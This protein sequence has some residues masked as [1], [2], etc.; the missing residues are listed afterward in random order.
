MRLVAAEQRA[1][2]S[3]AVGDGARDRRTSGST[4]WWATIRH[5]SLLPTRHWSI[6][7]RAI[8]STTSCHRSARPDFLDKTIYDIGDCYPWVVYV[9]GNLWLRDFRDRVGSAT[10]WRGVANYYAEYKFGM[11]GTRQLLDA[12]DAA[13]GKP[14]L[15]DRFPRLYAV[16]VPCLPFGVLPGLL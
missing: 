5:S 16:P 12:L 3:A 14:Q 1:G 10:F 9:Q 15:H 4:R 8:C 2:R 11:G 13:A 7:W 6:S